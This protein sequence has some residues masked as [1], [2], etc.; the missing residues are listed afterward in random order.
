MRK[1][2][3]RNISNHGSRQTSTP[4]EGCRGLQWGGLGWLG[5]AGV[6]RRWGAEWAIVGGVGGVGG[7]M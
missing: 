2:E 7:Q 1:K 5:V 6:G 4:A 3:L